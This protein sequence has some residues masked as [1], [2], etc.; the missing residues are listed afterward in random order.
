MLG[1]V[2]LG[3]TGAVG[4]RAWVT[5]HKRLKLGLAETCEMMKQVNNISSYRANGLNVP[6]ATPSLKLNQTN[7]IP[8]TGHLGEPAASL[9]YAGRTA[10]P[11]SEA[12][13]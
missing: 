13:G 4:Q 12:A 2:N 7:L 1:Q 3:L 9:P 6:K 10:T 5:S 11:N 8:Q